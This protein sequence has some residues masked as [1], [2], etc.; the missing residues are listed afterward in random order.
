MPA[1]RAVPLV[2]ISCHFHL[3][4]VPSHIC[5]DCSGKT[6]LLFH[7]A[8]NYAAAHEEA[9]YFVAQRHKLQNQLP[10]PPLNMTQDAEVLKR[11]KMKYLRPFSA[12]V[13]TRQR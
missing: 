4:N 1:G 5:M 13:L 9:V 3:Q 11:I 8:Y 7:Y 2:R 6:S 10:L 12:L